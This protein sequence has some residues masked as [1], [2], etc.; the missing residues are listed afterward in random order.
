MQADNIDNSKIDNNLEVN[1][2]NDEMCKMNENLMMDEIKM[3]NF[4]INQLENH[5]EI[6]SRTLPTIENKES[7]KKIY[8]VAMKCLDQI[9]FENDN[10]EKFVMKMDQNYEDIFKCSLKSHIIDKSVDYEKGKLRKD[11]SL[12]ERKTSVVANTDIATDPIECFYI[13]LC[14]YDFDPEISIKFFTKGMNFG[15]DKFKSSILA[16]NRCLANVYKHQDKVEEAIK[17][18]QKGID[19]KDSDTMI[20]YAEFLY[21]S[22]HIPNLQ[23]SL[24]VHYLKMATELGNTSAAYYLGDNYKNIDALKAL[25]YYKITASTQCKHQNYAIKA[26]SNIN[27]N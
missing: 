26:I 5:C 24:Y 14:L 4:I 10:Y 7:L 1:N 18:Y 11:I 6:E 9:N 22:S 12:F 21:Y 27:N 23:Q 3:M 20:C 15:D 17:L 13:G 8:D 16:C 19:A 2:L 25:E